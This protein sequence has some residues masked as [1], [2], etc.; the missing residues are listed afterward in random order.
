VPAD[1]TGSSSAEGLGQ[2]LKKARAFW[3]GLTPQQ[4][5]YTAVVGVLL[6][7]AA[8]KVATVLVLGVERVLIG[9]LLA[10]EEVI[11]QLLLKAGV[12]VRKGGSVW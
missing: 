12:V 9:A 3:E 1:A 2:L 4:Q 5:V 11:L 7:V 8:P 6:V 10:A